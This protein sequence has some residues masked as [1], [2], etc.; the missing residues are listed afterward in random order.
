M[1]SLP[2]RSKPAAR[3]SMFLSDDERA[4]IEKAR[5]SPLVPENEMKA[6]WKRLGIG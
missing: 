6:L 1:R 5:N 2:A 4:A 3:G